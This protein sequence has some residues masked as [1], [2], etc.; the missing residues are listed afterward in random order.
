MAFTTFSFAQT[1]TL[2]RGVG[3]YGY[4]TK[5]GGKELPWLEI[6]SLRVGEL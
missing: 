5:Y 3:Y 6:P 1:K 4:F 2:L